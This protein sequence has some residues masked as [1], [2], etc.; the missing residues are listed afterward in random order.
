MCY[1]ASFVFSD[2]IGRSGMFCA[3]SNALEQC[4]I[5][6]LVDVFQATKAVRTHKPGAVTSLV[7]TLSVVLSQMC[8]MVIVVKGLVD[9]ESN[10]VC[11]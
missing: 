3:V 6:G 9:R 4:K 11:I 2:T 5:E 1:F 10:C 8:C 7:S